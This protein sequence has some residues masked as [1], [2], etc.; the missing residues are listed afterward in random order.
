[1]LFRIRGRRGVVA[2]NTSVCPVNRLRPEILARNRS[3]PA[4]RKS[5]GSRR[6]GLA[7]IAGGGVWGTRGL[8]EMLDVLAARHLRVGRGQTRLSARAFA[9]DCVAREIERIPQI[10]GR[11]RSVVLKKASP[12]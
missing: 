4:P 9:N 5:N 12:K 3:K 8:Q 11:R 6:S 2:R 10:P 7:A 1:L